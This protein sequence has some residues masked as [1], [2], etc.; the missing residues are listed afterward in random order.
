[1]KWGKRTLNIRKTLYFVIVINVIQIALMAVVVVL[2]IFHHGQNLTKFPV[3]AFVGIS[4]GMV[5]LS[6]LL[7]VRDALNTRRLLDQAD[8]MATTIGNMAD[9]NNRLRAQRHDFLNHLQVVSGLIEMGEYEEASRYI[10]KVYGKITAVGRVLKTA[11]PAV[12]ALLQVKLG[13]C[14]KAGIAVELAIRSD[15][16]DLAMEGWEMC[17][18]LSN[19]IDNAMDAMRDEPEKRLRITLWDDMKTCR[20]AVANPG[21]PIPEDVQS[22]LFMPGFTTKETGHGMG[23][24]IVRTTLAEAGGGISLTREGGE[25]V[26]AGWAPRT[27]NAKETTEEE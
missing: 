4:A 2:T 9:L 17:K 26:F 8:S 23:L 20:F 22:R 12:N 1:M 13:A 21:A 15:W 3:R 18:V 10:E 19:L 5:A 25:N 7:D 16:Q 11:N 14:E 6:T 24:Y 27:L